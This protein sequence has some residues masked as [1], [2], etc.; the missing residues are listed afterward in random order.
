[1]LLQD[2]CRD[3][4]GDMS[5]HSLP[6]DRGLIDAPSH[7]DDLAGIE[8]RPDAHGD[9]H[10]RNHGDIRELIDIRQSRCIVQCHHAGDGIATGSRFVETDMTVQADPKD[11]EV[12]PAGFCD[13]LFIGGG[14]FTDVFLVDRSVRDMDIGRIYID[15]VEQMHLH[16]AMIA[17]K[18]IRFHRVVFIQVE[19]DHVAET[20]S[21]QTMHA[22]EFRVQ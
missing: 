17:L 7:Q 13:L 21:F 22:D 2:R 3:L 16:E 8:D 19:G 10:P 11:L 5:L 6:D 12:D 4:L 20:Q 9:G 15:V 14:V 1:M 18:G